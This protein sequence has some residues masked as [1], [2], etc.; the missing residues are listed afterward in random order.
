MHAY[1]GLALTITPI[2]ILSLI[3][4]IGRILNR[5]RFSKADIHDLEVNSSDSE[6]EDDATTNNFTTAAT[7]TMMPSRPAR[8][9]LAPE[10]IQ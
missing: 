5:K 3:I 10:R 1:L 9:V 6:K 4:T 2:L 7:S 8:A